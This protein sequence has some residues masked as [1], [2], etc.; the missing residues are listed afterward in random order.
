MIFIEDLPIKTR[1][2]LSMEESYFKA[3]KPIEWVIKD[4]IREYYKKY[5]DAEYFCTHEDYHSMMHWVAW[6][7]CHDEMEEE[8]L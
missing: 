3:P 4:A 2:K 8:L 6:A 1:E 7:D 5:K